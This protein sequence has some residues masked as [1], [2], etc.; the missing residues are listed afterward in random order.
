MKISAGRLLVI[1]LVLIALNI[2][3]LGFIVF[4]MTWR[5]KTSVSLQSSYLN[6]D[7]DRPDRLRLVFDRKIVSDKDLGRI[8]K[9]ALLEIHP[10]C[11][12]KLIWAEPDTLDYIF[13]EPLTPGRIYSASLTSR[14][15]RRTGMVV[16]N[17][18]KIEFQT[19]PL[20]MESCFV[21][22]ADDSEVTVELQFNQPID[23]ADL[24][25]YVTFYDGPGA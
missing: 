24:L 5:P 8:E 9:R 13:D 2:L 4:K 23:P 1:N 11:P 17:T 3:G 6:P 15:A 12:G 10:A 19:S 20:R 14:F 18:E 16:T 22:A 21:I 7:T 25:R